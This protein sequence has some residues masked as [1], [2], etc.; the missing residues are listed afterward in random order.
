ML[1]QR[2]RRWPN[3]KTALDQCL[4]RVVSCNQFSDYI[5]AVNLYS[6][7]HCWPTLDRL[8][9]HILQLND[10]LNHNYDE[11][12]LTA[13]ICG[14]SFAVILDLTHLWWSDFGRLF[15]FMKYIPQVTE[16]SVN[17]LL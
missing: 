13:R 11:L 4:V 12:N 16:P 14:P 5:N 17:L 8:G 2:R 9:M 1:S 10:S 6:I 3:I 7:G 15:S